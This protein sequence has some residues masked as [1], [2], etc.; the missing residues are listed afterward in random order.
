MVAESMEELTTHMSNAHVK[1]WCDEC[2]IV[3][4]RMNKLNSHKNTK[5]E[6][7][8]LA[9]NVVREKSEL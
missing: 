4:D 9:S 1:F 5:H 8:R 6:N 3:T 7:M 2:G